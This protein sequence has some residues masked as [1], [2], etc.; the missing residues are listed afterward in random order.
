VPQRIYPGWLPPTPDQRAALERIRRMQKE[1]ILWFA[2]FLP[3]GWIVALATRD[4]SAFVP[5]TVFWITAGAILARRVIEM[6][7]PR[8]GATFC[9]KSGLPYIYG[10]F[11][12]RCEGCG[13]TLNSSSEAGR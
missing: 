9:A 1:V 6:H 13:L 10:L 8:C 11:N 2:A 3:A 7:C 4:D 12:R 5:L